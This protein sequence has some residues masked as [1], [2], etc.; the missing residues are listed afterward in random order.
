MTEIAKFLPTNM[1]LSAG[2]LHPHLIHVSLGP[3]ESTT[4]TAYRS[5]ET[6]LHSS[7]QNVPVLYN[8]LPLPL[9]LAPS[10]TGSAP[11][12]NA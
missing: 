10:H 8:G 2:G 5:V 3:L 1:S 12:S 6:F 11:P 7:R 4:Q 9:K